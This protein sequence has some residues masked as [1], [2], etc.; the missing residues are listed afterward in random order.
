MQIYGRL[1]SA[2]AIIRLINKEATQGLSRRKGVI[3]ISQAQRFCGGSSIERQGMNIP[4]PY[5]APVASYNA[6]KCTLVNGLINLPL[7]LSAP[8]LDF[9]RKIQNVHFL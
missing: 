4:F 8:L 6:T 2:A 9:K 1:A 7:L 5:V 3:P